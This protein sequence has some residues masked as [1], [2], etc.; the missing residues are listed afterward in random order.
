ME[1]LKEV[2]QNHTASNEG[3]KVVAKL[4]L[5]SSGSRECVN[6]SMF[7]PPQAPVFSS[8]TRIFPML[9]D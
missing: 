8:I 7:Y 1:R 6:M 2:A 4:Q 9:Q 5:Q 3:R